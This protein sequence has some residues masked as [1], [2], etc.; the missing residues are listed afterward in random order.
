[1][2]EPVPVLDLVGPSVRQEPRARG[3]RDGVEVVWSPERGW[4]CADHTHQPCTH[5][6]DLPRPT[7]P[8]EIS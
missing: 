8:Q 1:M 2:S 5:T 3:L 7:L 4:L 6:A